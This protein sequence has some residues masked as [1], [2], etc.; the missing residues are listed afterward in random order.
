MKTRNTSK[1]VK[2]KFYSFNYKISTISVYQR[3]QEGILNVIK[4][5]LYI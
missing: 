1:S 3:M 4:F 5:K 2:N